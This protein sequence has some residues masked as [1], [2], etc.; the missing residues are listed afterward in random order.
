MTH[1]ALR[2]LLAIGLG[3]GGA[4]S[5]LAQEG[6]L[7]RR[8][9]EAPSAAGRYD[10]SL[11]FRTISTSRFDI[12][13][14]QGEEA[15]AAR[16]AGWAEQVA[17]RVNGALGTPR[18]RVQV[19]LV[20]QTDQSNGWATVFPFNLIEL[21]AVPPSSLSTIGN[22]DDWLPLVFAHE[23]A[24]I[25]HL[26]KSRGWF[27]RLRPIFGRLPLLS[28]NIFLPEW[29][30]EGLATFEESRVTGQGRVPAGDFRL[31]LDAAAAEGRLLPLDRASG[32]LL[33]W[34]SGNAAYLYGAY[35]H[36][37]LARRY[38]DDA[39]RRLAET[40]AGQL[41]YLGSR[42]FRRVF[43]RPLGALWQDFAA[44]TAASQANQAVGA[45]AV[46]LTHHGFIV[47]GPRFGSGGEI[48]YSVANPH[49]FPALM[50]LEGA[51][52]RPERLA[53]R[54]HGAALGLT[55]G[56]VVFDQLEVVRH[57]G[58]QSDLYAAPRRGGRTRRLTHGA[59]AADPDVARDGVS[60]VCTVQGSGRRSLAVLTLPA[61]G[62]S[63]TP[64][65]L[66][67]EAATEF[68]SPRWSPDGRWIAAERRRPGAASEIVI[69]DAATREVRP[70]VGGA[71]GR[72]A[73]PS[74]MP[75][76]AAILFASDRDGPFRIHAVDLA[77]GV[78]RRLLGTGEGAHSP[79]VS[80]DGRQVVFVGYS[81]DGYDL[82]LMDL[83]TA[84]WSAPVSGRA[85]GGDV[86]TRGGAPDAES[87]TTSMAPVPFPDARPALPATAAV[88]SGSRRYR[89]W[90]TLT[91]RY[92]TPLVES[93][94]DDLRIGAATSGF[95]ALGRHAYLASGEWLTAEREAVWQ[96]DYAYARWWP[97]LF[98][99]ASKSI[100][101]WRTGDVRSRE[102]SAGMLLPLP[103]VRWGATG[104]VS[105]HA[106]RDRYDCP[107]CV[108]PVGALT[109]RR[110]LRLGWQATS[111]RAFGYSISPEEGALAS[112][113]TEWSRGSGR[114][115][116]TAGAAT[117]DLR[118]YWRVFPRHAAVAA[119]LAGAAAWGDRG[120]RRVFQASG[121]GPQAAGFD[122]GSG[123]I[124]LLRGFRTSD[125]FGYRAAVL[126]LEYRVPLA[127]PQR[128]L[129]TTPVMLRRLHAAAFADA[130]H[131]WDSRFRA[132]DVRRS[133][134][135][136]LSA[137]TVIGY[138]LPL[139]LTAGGAWREDPSGRHRGWAAFTRAGRSF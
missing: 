120:L 76:G 78:V 57:V 83:Q 124:G 52:R 75:D 37:Y 117:G 21:T 4:G 15:L 129:G 61:P 11:R 74:W 118:A 2:V 80:A 40:T 64:R 46:R 6:A 43:G 31:L 58:L 137:D 29:Q 72:N 44:E 115:P 5:A 131:G 32:G 116:G 111:A 16:V 132:A 3:L 54:Y 19:V 35:F 38:G 113:T 17:A 42:A 101:R 73:S 130:G 62:R 122:F 102:A 121:S 70:V 25:V 68:S 82:H 77:T 13:Y 127:W 69:V 135:L 106:S 12:H 71:R 119:R 8:P 39:I 66:V 108:V 110:D 105:L 55:G 18:G 14:H 50:R 128:G 138:A 90:G 36:E 94:R 98:A 88:A 20:D 100:D 47:A 99:S 26:E 104:L 139:T 45:S 112:A 109:A 85:G 56:E 86:V 136:E 93:R 33:D 84:A 9:L 30:V 95:D 24:H 103:H 126:N 23:Y 1:Q 125:V 51:G 87:A 92:W 59:R 34:P 97:T 22:T 81:A 41:P 123:A 10:P 53:A 49:G 91:P 60:I 133:F 63:G 27:G 89:P 79:S 65:M 96:V 7:T 48:F 114:Q 67:S 28:P 134:G 107:A